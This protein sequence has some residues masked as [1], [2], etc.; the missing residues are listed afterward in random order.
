MFPREQEQ[1][2]QFLRVSDYMSFKS[3]VYMHLWAQQYTYKSWTF[4]EMKYWDHVRIFQPLRHLGFLPSYDT[5]P[6]FIKS[7]SFQLLVS[8]TIIPDLKPP[9]WVLAALRSCT[10]HLAF[11]STPLILSLDHHFEHAFSLYFFYKF[12]TPGIM[13]DISQNPY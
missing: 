5:Q 11:L 7:I 9:S 13:S 2:H 8:V 3:N 1:E 10:R 6:M 12:L 4:P